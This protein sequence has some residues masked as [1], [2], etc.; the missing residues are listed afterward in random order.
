MIDTALYTV[1]YPAAMKY[2]REWYE[3]VQ[4]QAYSEFDLWISLDKVTQEEVASV[5][6]SE[7]NARW[8]CSSQ[9]DSP[10]A[11]RQEAMKQMVESYE[12]IVFVDCDDVLDPSRVAAAKEFLQRYDVVACALEIIDEPGNDLGIVF[13]LTAS[14]DAQE[15]LPRYNVFGLSNSA[16]RSDVLKG[17]LPFAKDCVLIDW[18]LATRA[19]SSGASLFFDP[20]PR[21][22][23]R[24][25][26]GNTAQVVKP[27]TETDIVRACECVLKH[28]ECVL[29]P[30][31]VLPL[32]HRKAIEAAQKRAKKFY[33]AITRSSDV[34]S[35]YVAAVN[36][37]A[38]RYVWWWTVANPQLEMIW[39]N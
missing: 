38:P 25:Y 26:P 6:G 9:G 2:V 16:Y 20:V 27:F 23:Y 12:G 18:L 31:M 33:N 28:Y 3:S 35:R 34:R 22:L 1:I 17:C 24:Q 32:A 5:I 4:A 10:A 30:E 37:L 11:I 8:I 39:K 14:E 7:P 29:G 19:W 13:G 21:M 36:E 15:M